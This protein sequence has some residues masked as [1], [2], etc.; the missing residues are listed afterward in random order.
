MTFRKEV[1]IVKN[2]SLCQFPVY[3]PFVDCH[4]KSTG[5]RATGRFFH[6][7]PYISH[8]SFVRLLENQLV[9][10]YNIKFSSI[11]YNGG[12]THVRR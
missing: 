3:H 2:Q 6:I 7:Y 5:H 8:N 12:G 1:T 10:A 9:T 4:I 11:H